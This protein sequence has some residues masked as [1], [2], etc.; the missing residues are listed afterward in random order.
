[1]VNGRTQ[2]NLEGVNSPFHESTVALSATGNT[3]FLYRDEDGGDFF[4]SERQGGAWSKPE[5]L[6]GTINS[7]FVERS[8]SITTDEKTIYFSS[9][10]PGGKGGLDLYTATK[11]N[12]GVW[13]NIKALSKLNTDFDEDGPFIDHDGKTLYF[14]S[15]MPGGQGG[16]DIWKTSINTD[17]SYTTPENMGVRVNTEGDESFPS[18][19][20]DNNTLY[21]AS[22]GH[23]TG[24]CAGQVG[25]GVIPSG[26]LL[27][28]PVEPRGDFAG[29]GRG[30]RGLDAAGP[31]ED[32]VLSGL[33]NAVE[34]GILFLHL[35]VEAVQ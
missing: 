24:Q 35:V 26:N 29:F 25:E 21:F 8:M 9:D 32:S 17:G 28:R 13:S 1:M 22:D 3:L 12:K 31:G 15:N 6:D 30:A 16:N 4:V 10:R 34:V 27:E 18:I 20:Q 5:S 33:Q 19:S 11:D 14:S 2:K 7:S 23:A